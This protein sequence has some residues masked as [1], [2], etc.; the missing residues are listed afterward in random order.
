MGGGGGG[1]GGGAYFPIF[2]EI[3]KIRLKKMRHCLPY[4]ALQLHHFIGSELG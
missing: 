1:G 2:I 3:L 4:A